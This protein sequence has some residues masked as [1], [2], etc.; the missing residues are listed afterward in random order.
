[1]PI[2]ASV[3]TLVTL[4]EA[5]A[6][7]VKESARDD[8]LLQDLVNRASDYCEW[9]CNR[10]LRA[11]AFTNLRL[12]ARCS[13]MLRPLS[14]PIY[15]ERLDVGSD[16]S[17]DAGAATNEG[18]GTVGIPVTPHGFPVGTIVRLAATVNY[19][20]AR[21]T[22][23]AASTANTVVITATYVAETFT[24]AMTMFETPDLPTTIT[25]TVDGTAQTIWAKEADGE[26][27]DFDVVVA[28][29]VHDPRALTHFYP[30]CGLSVYSPGSP[31][32]ILLSYTCG[33]VTIPGELKDACFLVL[34]NLYRHQVKQLADVAALTGGPAGGVTFRE[35]LIP[36]K[37]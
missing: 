22:V 8:D 13:Y 20:A 30:A 15:A 1:M 6:F 11:Q 35:S 14:T 37:A 2:S 7:M 28:A 27:K 29:D 18:G 32:P 23:L 31:A 19:S 34:Q 10:P 21:Y 36:L 12:P 4:D 26:Q 16:R 33:F 9:W 5:R 24:A 25:I 3:N 17:L